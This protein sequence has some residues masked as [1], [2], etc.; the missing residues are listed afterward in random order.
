MAQQLDLL[1]VYEVVL[2]R[3]GRPDDVDGIAADR[4]VRPAL[5]LARS[6]AERRAL[7]VARLSP[8]AGRRRQDSRTTREA[9][10]QEEQIHYAQALRTLKS[11]WTPALAADVFHV[12]RA[13]R[14]SSRGA[15]A[16]VVSW[17]TSGATRSPT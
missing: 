12:D 14:A 11:G 3:F 13:V 2:N 1:R 4:P 5:S 7:P 6:R 9:P 17:P 16:F 10:T 8:G 15:T